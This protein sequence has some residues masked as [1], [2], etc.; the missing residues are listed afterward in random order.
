M[1]KVFSDYA[2]VSQLCQNMTRC[3]A[4]ST[5]QVCSG[6]Y[7]R[8]KRSEEKD[9]VHTLCEREPESLQGLPRLR[10]SPFASLC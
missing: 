4:P 10:G 9:I 1:M 6:E 2:Y 3:Q 8:E 5:R 7:A